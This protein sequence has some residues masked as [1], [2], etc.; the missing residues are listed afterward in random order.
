MRL[1]ELAEASGGKIKRQLPQGKLLK[2]KVGGRWEGDLGSRL[3]TT[4]ALK[5]LHNP[6]KIN[7]CCPGFLTYKMRD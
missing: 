6:G 5:Q 1:S 3:F 4:P 2:S 7:Q